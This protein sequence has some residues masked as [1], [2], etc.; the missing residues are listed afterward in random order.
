MIKIK[1][2]KFKFHKKI[3]LFFKTYLGVPQRYRWQTLIKYIKDNNYKSYAEIGV[4]TGKN[5][6][7][8]LDACPALEKVILIDPYDESIVYTRGAG[9][10]NKKGS[11]SP[12]AFH[13]AKWRLQCFSNVEFIKKT[14]EEAAKL[15]DDESID[16]AFIDAQHDKE[17]VSR[18]I[19]C[20]WPKIKKNGILSGHDYAPGIS[21]G[22]AD[23]VNSFFNKKQII[24]FED[25][26]WAVKKL[27]N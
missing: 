3:Q 11:V 20:W 8:I 17:N 6:F 23:A 26:V 10:G 21:G 1:H 5:A 18:D 9:V 24:L 27:I 14:S 12:N 22:V 7:E 25:G 2:K 16:I 4:F 13:L 19:N 15:I